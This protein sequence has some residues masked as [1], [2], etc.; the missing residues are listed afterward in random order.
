M[1]MF[2]MNSGTPFGSNFTLSLKSRPKSRPM[3]KQETEAGMDFARDDPNTV[4]WDGPDDPQC[5][6]N[7]TARN[8][9]THTVL[10]SITALVL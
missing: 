2:D 9:Y 7:W 4:D 6:R 1:N 8:R 3:S 5:P 10:V